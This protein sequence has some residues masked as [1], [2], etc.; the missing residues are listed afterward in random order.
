M[1]K[2]ALDIVI[3][4]LVLVVGLPVFLA[5]AL[6]IAMRDGRPVVFT[7]T[8]IGRGGKQFTIYKFRT[9][10]TDAED[11]QHHLLHDNERTGP[12]FKVSNDPR[13][14]RSGRVLRR[15]SVDELPQFLNVLTGTMSVV[16]PRPALPAE[17]ERFP[18]ELRRREQMRPGITGLWQ[19]DGRT[20]ADFGKY[21]SLDLRYVDEWS[22][23]LDLRTMLR[24]PGVMW[25]HARQRW[26]VHNPEPATTHPD[27]QEM[28]V[29]EAANGPR[30]D[31]EQLL[32]APVL[33]TTD[34]AR[35]L[36]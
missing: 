31:A 14:T 15:S 28:P 30:D 27:P 25:R 8:R 13:I 1:V 11:R 16:G 12:L 33:D 34:A 10:T 24:T 21:T 36:A 6:Y 20:D 19:V 2:R 22:L 7:Q 26:D 9:M 3:A 5:I 23:R 35:R 29:P 4:L 32:A 18:N 17:V